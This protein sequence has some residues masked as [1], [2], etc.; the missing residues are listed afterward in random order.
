MPASTVPPPPVRGL[1]R[2][3]PDRSNPIRK[4]CLNSPAAPSRE[5]KHEMERGS[6]V[7][8]DLAILEA[9]FAALDQAVV[10]HDERGTIV[11]CNPAVAKL[12]GRPVD[13][14]LGK[15]PDDFEI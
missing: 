1:A 9:G 7:R 13:E 3:S 11:A 2:P 8:G 5:G 14:I 15:G 4:I 12:V 6:Y 10:V